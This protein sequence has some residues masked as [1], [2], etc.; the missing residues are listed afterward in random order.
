MND[1][2]PMCQKA[3]RCSPPNG[4]VALHHRLEGASKCLTAQ[5]TSNE[6]LTFTL[7]LPFYASDEEKSEDDDEE[8]RESI[9]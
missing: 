6:L 9:R 7:V 5:T 8:E 4:G 2:V 3:Q 1:T